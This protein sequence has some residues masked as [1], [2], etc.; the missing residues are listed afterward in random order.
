MKKVA[1]F[2]LIIAIPVLSMQVDINLHRGWNLVA[3]PCSTGYSSIAEFLPSFGPAY[4]YE[5]SGDYSPITT[6]PK[7]SKGFWLL[8]AVDTL[9]RV[10]CI[11]VDDTSLM[12][13]LSGYTFIDSCLGSPSR[14]VT[15]TMDTNIY[16]TITGCNVHVDY[17]AIFDCNIDSVHTLLSS[18]R[19][20][21]FFN[22]EVF[23]ADPYPC[24]CYYHMSVDFVVGKS[25]T[26]FLKFNDSFWAW[27][28][29][30]EITV[31]GCP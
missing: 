27:R 10:D 11:C 13:V 7:P 6:L 5:F 21:I 22:Y 3:I 29:T 24:Y 15:D 9:I 2:L 16:I 25:G 31:T 26:F 1:I 30:R 28:G 19:D 8:S 14:D 12:P 23:A 4:I 20:T 17:C 18:V